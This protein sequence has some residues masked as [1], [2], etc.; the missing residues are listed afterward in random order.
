MWVWRA[1]Q[2]C[3]L[4]KRFQKQ[5]ARSKAQWVTAQQV[6]T[7]QTASRHGAARSGSHG[8]V[9]PAL[10]KER[11]RPKEVSGK[12]SGD[13]GATLAEG[14]VDTKGGT[15]PIRSILRI[16]AFCIRRPLN[17]DRSKTSAKDVMS[18]LHQKRNWQTGGR[19]RGCPALSRTD[20]N[21]ITAIYGCKP[22]GRGPR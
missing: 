7:T 17:A 20:T 2:Q 21:M 22:P 12:L 16:P 4:L 5:V 10:E 9:P 3:P 6:V 18:T 1:I 19:D 15:R 14:E 13:K 11:Q 8:Y